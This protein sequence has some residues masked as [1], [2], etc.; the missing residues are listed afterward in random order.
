MYQSKNKITAPCVRRAVEKGT[1]SMTWATIEQDVKTSRG[2]KPSANLPA[3][4]TRMPQSK[5]GIGANTV[6]TDA[7]PSVAKRE[8][9]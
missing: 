6:P 5:M 8:A 9:L 1:F 2:F 7:I 3:K 4:P